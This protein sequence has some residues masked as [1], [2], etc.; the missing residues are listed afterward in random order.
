[1]M[2]AFLMSIG[3]LVESFVW[4]RDRLTQRAGRVNV[5]TIGTIGMGPLNHDGIQ[6]SGRFPD[7]VNLGP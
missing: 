4:N 1:V 6:A 5:G 2:I 3:R 7:M